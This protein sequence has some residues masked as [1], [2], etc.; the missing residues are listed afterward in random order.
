VSTSCTL[1]RRWLL[2]RTLGCL[3]PALTVRLNHVLVRDAAGRVLVRV[4]NWQ[5][6]ASMQ[7]ISDLHAKSSAAG[8]RVSTSQVDSADSEV[9]LASASAALVRISITACAN[10]HGHASCS[11]L[12]VRHHA[13]TIF[14]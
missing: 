8:L 4:D 5:A 12:P 9:S 1:L 10:V 6:V 3:M 2:K 11:G 7:G 13:L 14:L